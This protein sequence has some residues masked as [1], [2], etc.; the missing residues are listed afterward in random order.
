MMDEIC[1]ESLLSQE[2]VHHSSSLTSVWRKRDEEDSDVN[3]Q[4]YLL[5]NDQVA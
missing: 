3:N 4:S 1:A 2:A 5:S